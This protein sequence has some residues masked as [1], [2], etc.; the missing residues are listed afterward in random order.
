MKTGQKHNE[1]K[2]KLK[3][4]EQFIFVC[5]YTIKKLYSDFK[6]R[7]FLIAQTFLQQLLL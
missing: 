6:V 7:T 4:C 5:G 1:L 2:N 3:K